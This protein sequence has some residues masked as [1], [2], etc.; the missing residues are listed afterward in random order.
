MNSEISIG[1]LANLISRLMNKKISY[2]S[3]EDRI[4]PG[5][6]EVERLICDNTKLIETTDW[7][8]KFVLEKGITEVIEWME[9]PNNF[10]FY[11]SAQ[12]NV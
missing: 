2:K 1:E 7:R 5:S 6:S 4:R 3:T 12:Y 9:N 8:P 11:K 10:S